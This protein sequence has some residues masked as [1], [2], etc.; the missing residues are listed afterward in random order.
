MLDDR[1]KVVKR[2]VFYMEGDLDISEHTVIGNTGIACFG[3]ILLFIK[4][5]TGSLCIISFCAILQ[6]GDQYVY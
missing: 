4:E 1:F 5:E 3:F 6:F 2:E